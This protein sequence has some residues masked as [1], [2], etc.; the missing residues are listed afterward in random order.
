M[1]PTNS[2]PLCRLPVLRQTHQKVISPDTSWPYSRKY[3]W[4]R[5]LEEVIEPQGGNTHYWCLFLI[6]PLTHSSKTPPTSRHRAWKTA[7]NDDCR[8]LVRPPPW[9]VPSTC[10]WDVCVWVERGP[11]YL[12][13]LHRD[14]AQASMCGRTHGDPSPPIHRQSLITKPNYAKLEF[15]LVPPPCGKRIY[16]PV[17]RKSG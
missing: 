14:G 3:E 15:P 5:G 7:S 4:E 13:L 10:V 9:I 17:H 12:I 1:C 16:V 8:G 6:N 2:F 11:F